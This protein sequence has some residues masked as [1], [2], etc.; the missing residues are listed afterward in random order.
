MVIAPVFGD[1]WD[2]LLL[3][4][5]HYQ[6]FQCF[7]MFAIFA[8]I[9]GYAL[10][11]KYGVLENPP[12]S[13]IIFNY[14]GFFFAACVCVCVL[15]LWNQQ[16]LFNLEHPLFNRSNTSCLKLLIRGG[17]VS[18]AICLGEA[19]EFIRVFTTIRG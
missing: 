9:N 12:F 18:I 19:P 4:L 7:H 10:F 17:S 14:G 16:V 1:F 11:I 3:G 5:P 8:F 13:S 6:C 2:G 15:C